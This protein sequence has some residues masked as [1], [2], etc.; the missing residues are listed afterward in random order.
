MGQKTWLTPNKPPYACSPTIILKLARLPPS[1]APVCVAADSH[2]N[3]PRHLDCTS[4]PAATCPRTPKVRLGLA[5]PVCF[6]HDGMARHPVKSATGFRDVQV[7]SSRRYTAKISVDNRWVWPSKFDTPERATWRYGRPRW[8]LTSLMCRADRR[9]SPCSRNV[10][11]V[12][13]REEGTPPSHTTAHRP[14]V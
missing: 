4:N 12:T 6:G 11:G 8:C 1:S 5:A 13:Q 7:R 9:Q 3:K 14:R 2:H 10:G